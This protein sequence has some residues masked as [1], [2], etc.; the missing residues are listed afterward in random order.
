MANS[1]HSLQHLFTFCC[2][3]LFCFVLFCF[4]VQE[5]QVGAAGLGQLVEPTAYLAVIPPCDTSGSG[6]SS[7]AGGYDLQWLVVSERVHRSGPGLLHLCK[8]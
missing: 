5:T 3:V 7:H 2:F 8:V 6:L 4:V 1:V